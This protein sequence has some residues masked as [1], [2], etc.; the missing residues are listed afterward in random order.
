ML[1]E[2]WLHLTQSADPSKRQVLF[3]DLSGFIQAPEAVKPENLAEIL[4]G[5]GCTFHGLA[6]VS[7]LYLALLV[8]RKPGVMDVIA[9]HL[10]AGLFNF[11][12]Q[13]T[14]RLTR[15]R[16]LISLSAPLATPSSQN[17]VQTLTNA[18]CAATRSLIQGGDPIEIDYTAEILRQTFNLLAVTLVKSPGYQGVP[19]AL[20]SGLLRAYLG[21]LLCSNA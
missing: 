3:G 2:A 17:A 13:S 14:A 21:I 10:L 8:P 1:G 16:D 7:T 4:E 11:S 15:K 12:T 9:A 19:V 18:L 6:L 5:V 20:K